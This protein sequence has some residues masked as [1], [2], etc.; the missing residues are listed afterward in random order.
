MEYPTLRSLMLAGATGVALVATAP[1]A[2]QMRRAWRRISCQ[3]VCP[4]LLWLTG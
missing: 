2:A 3:G 4:M 1:A